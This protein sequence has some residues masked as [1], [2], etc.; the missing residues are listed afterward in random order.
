MEYDTTNYHNFP[1]HQNAIANHFKQIG[2]ALRIVGP[3]LTQS[4]NDLSRAIE[5]CP[6]MTK[7]I[8]QNRISTLLDKASKWARTDSVESLCLRGYRKLVERLCT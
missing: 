1:S 3:I 6:I 4:A 5:I 2:V 8:A 7:C